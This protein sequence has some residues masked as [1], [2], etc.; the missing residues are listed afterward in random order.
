MRI[1]LYFDGGIR[2]VAQTS[3]LARAQRGFCLRGL[4]W[5]AGAASGNERFIIPGIIR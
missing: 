4:E 1:D 2:R 3:G 5:G